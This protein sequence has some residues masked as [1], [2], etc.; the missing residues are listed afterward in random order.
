MEPGIAKQSSWSIDSTP[1]LAMVVTNGTKLCSKAVCKNLVFEMQGETFAGEVRLLPLE[2]CDMVLGIQWL[3][4][5]GP[6]LWNFK[7]LS[8][9]FQLQRKSLILKRESQ[10][11]E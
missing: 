10:K 7:N 2:G 5:L 11:I 1:N 6:I 4:T 3:L 9:Q 8:M